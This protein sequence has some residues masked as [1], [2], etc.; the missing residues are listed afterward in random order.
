MNRR[1]SN[2]A[3]VPLVIDKKFYFIEFRTCMIEHAMETLLNN[4]PALFNFQYYNKEYYI[5][6]GR[7]LNKDFETIMHITSYEIIVYNPTD[8]FILRKWNSII[9]LNKKCTINKEGSKR[10][11]T[12]LRSHSMKYLQ[13]AI[14]LI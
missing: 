14:A 6:K 13:A 10:Y 1:G 7:L 3:N 12:T 9:N 5:Y 2:I 4:Y 8:T 11:A